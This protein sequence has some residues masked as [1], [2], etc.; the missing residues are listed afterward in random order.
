MHGPRRNH[1][2]QPAIA[3]QREADVKWP[4]V[5]GVAKSLQSELMNTVANI[6]DDQK[7]IVEKDLLGFRLSN[8]M[9]LDTLAAIPFIPIKALDPPKVK[10]F[11]YYRNIRK[12]QGPLL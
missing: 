2:D 9:L 5:I 7:R 1:P 12:K 4:P 3:A 6:L 11:V 8:T 10:H